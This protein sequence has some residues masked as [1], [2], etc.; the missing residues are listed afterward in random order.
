VGTVLFSILVF[1]VELFVVV[2]CLMHNVLPL[3][4]LVSVTPYYEEGQLLH[5]C[6]IKL[7]NDPR[8]CVSIPGT[9]TPVSTN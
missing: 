4:R 8:V 5:T 6:V 3:L 7:D 2:L 9:C 1:Y